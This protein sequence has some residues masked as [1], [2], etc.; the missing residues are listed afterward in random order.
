MAAW[1]PTATKFRQR[2]ACSLSAAWYTLEPE[3][4]KN[5]FVDA[6]KKPCQPQSQA[7]LRAQPRL[8]S[9]LGIKGSFTIIDI[10]ENVH[11]VR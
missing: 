3:L 6:Q 8:S 1:E 11:S 7:M 4:L 2:E 9:H 10:Y 5:R